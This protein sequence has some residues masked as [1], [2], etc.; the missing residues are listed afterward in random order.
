MSQEKPQRPEQEPTK[1]G[2][3]DLGTKAGDELEDEGDPNPASAQ[4]PKIEV[5]QDIDFISNQ[6]GGAM[7]PRFSRNQN[8]NAWSN[9]SMDKMTSN[10]NPEVINSVPGRMGASMATATATANRLKKNK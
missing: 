3:V 6:G 10:E 7:N 1:Y 8:E 2:D 5:T 4:A 9:D